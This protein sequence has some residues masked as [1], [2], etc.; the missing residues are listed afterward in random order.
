MTSLL[1]PS[2]SQHEI[3]LAQ[4]LARISE[5]PVQIQDLWNPDRCPAHLLP[6]LAW[7]LSIDE[8]DGAW[9]EATQR[10][11]I[12]Q[13]ATLHR[14]KGTVGAVRKAL[15]PLGLAVDLME[16][17]QRPNDLILANIHN[18][19]PHTFRFITWVQQQRQSRQQ[20]PLNPQRYANV[21]R[22]VEQVKPVRSHFDFF[23][24][25]KFHSPLKVQASST[26]A[27]QVGRL[28]QQLSPPPITLLHSPL[29]A[30][31][32]LNKKRYAVAKFY[33][34]QPSP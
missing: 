2:A 21:R 3:H 4:S 7:S 11:F 16:W 29:S 14:Q 18:P 15:K 12:K 13:S 32:H 30:H 10:D 19:T 31:L 1:P 17:F 20:T 34:V 25:A 23:V 28:S 26:G 5:L 8:W 22:L 6:W 27:I 33:L 24:G 9:D